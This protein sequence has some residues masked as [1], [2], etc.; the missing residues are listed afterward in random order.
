MVHLALLQISPVSSGK[1]SQQ[2][3]INKQQDQVVLVEARRTLQFLYHK[4]ERDTLRCP[5]RCLNAESWPR[6]G[7]SMRPCHLRCQQRPPSAA[8]GFTNM[9]PQEN[10][11]VVDVSPFE[12]GLT[13]GSSRSF[14]QGKT[15]ER[16]TR[17]SSRALAQALHRWMGL[18]HLRRGSPFHSIPQVEIPINPTLSSCAT[19][20]I[21]F[22]IR[23]S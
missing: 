22:I 7:C 19:T 15:T 1:L 20:V 8:D 12:G 11:G 10:G 16:T 2:H 3:L 6:S 18:R 5:L 9:E 23:L 21:F 14:F 13:L 17:A 4:A